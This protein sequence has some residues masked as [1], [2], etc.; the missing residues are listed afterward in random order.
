MNNNEPEQSADGRARAGEGTS[1][2]DQNE[3]IVVENDGKALK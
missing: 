3:E 2:E 1:E